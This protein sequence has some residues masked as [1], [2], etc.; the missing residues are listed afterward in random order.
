MGGSRVEL[1]SSSVRLKLY[2]DANDV[3]AIDYRQASQDFSIHG[4]G[5][6]SLR[7][8]RGGHRVGRSPQTFVDDASV[9][10]AP[11]ERM[12]AGDSSAGRLALLVEL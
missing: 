1:L 7:I 5:E 12:H 9:Q 2:P 11:K 6:V 8:G 3:A 10:S 4:L